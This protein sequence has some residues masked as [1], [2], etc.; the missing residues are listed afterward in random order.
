MVLLCSQS[1][2]VFHEVTSMEVVESKNSMLPAELLPFSALLESNLFPQNVK[3][4]LFYP[5]VVFALSRVTTVRIS[6]QVKGVYLFFCCDLC[7]FWQMGHFQMADGSGNLQLV[8]LLELWCSISFI[9]GL[10]SLLFTLDWV[11]RIFFFLN[12]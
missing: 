6:D 10:C 3:G 9:L 4:E 12:R 2:R 7:T 11:V 8:L 1:H 5:T